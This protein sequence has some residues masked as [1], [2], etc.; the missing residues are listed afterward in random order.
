MRARVGK[1]TYMAVARVKWIIPGKQ[2][3]LRVR[4]SASLW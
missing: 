3:A 1:A 2:E 4:S